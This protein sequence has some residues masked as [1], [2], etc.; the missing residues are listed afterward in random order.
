MVK[1]TSIISLLAA[2]LATVSAALHY[3]QDIATFSPALKNSG[4]FKVYDTPVSV[5][6]DSSTEG[7]SFIGNTKKNSSVKAKA[8]IAV[9]YLA[10][11]HNIPAE[12]IKVTDAYT[13]DRSGLTHVYVRQ[14]SG[15]VD[16]VN[17]LANINIDSK[18]QI[19]S[20]SQTFAST[21]A[22][23]KVKRSN[24]SLVAR[25]GDEA[26][27]KNAFKS[28]NDYVKTPVSDSDMSKVSVAST[29]DFVSG[30]PHY[31]ITNVPSHAAVDGSASAKKALI[32]KADGS[33]VH[34]WDIT[35]KQ[36]D[37]W[38]SA[39][40]NQDTGSVEAIHDW[41]SHAECYNV[42]PRTVLDPSAGCRS[43]V[44]NPADTTA[45]PKGWVN[46]TTTTGNNVWAQN[47]PTG[48]SAWM[49]NHR[50]TATNGLFDFPLDLTKAPSSY[51]DAAITQLFYTVNTMHDLSYLYG[52]N[53]AAGNFQDINYSG[54]GVGGDYVVAFAQDGSGTDNANFATPPDGQHG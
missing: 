27:L 52:F 15:G 12:N 3:H 25:A 36:A 44:R 20:S 16:V 21:D 43:I 7:A 10:K 13:D 32:Q 41:V 28:L 48:G 42:F 2:S 5:T 38:W 53:E 37:H 45:S 29:L 23:S 40:V 19:I 39:H 8:D 54:S 51:A 30:E 1:L 17:G 24:G 34:I 18:G 47:N 14:T 49:S 4:N 11:N 6:A 50:P 26:S 35:L 22:L 33:L 31:S 9:A 46:G